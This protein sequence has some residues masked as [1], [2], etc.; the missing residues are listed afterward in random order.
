M[1]VCENMFVTYEFNALIKEEEIPFLFHKEN[2]K[3]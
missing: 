3:L 1:H 2:I